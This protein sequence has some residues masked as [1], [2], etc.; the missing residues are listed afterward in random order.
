MLIAAIG[1]S[2]WEVG[3]AF[4]GGGRMFGR[5]GTTTRMRG[6]NDGG[7]QKRRVLVTVCTLVLMFSAISLYHG[8]FFSN[9]SNKLAEDTFDPSAAGWAA[10]LAAGI[11]GESAKGREVNAARADG[12][13]K[14]VK[15]DVDVRADDEFEAKEEVAAEKDDFAEKLE[16]NDDESRTSESDET[17]S[18]LAAPKA[19][20]VSSL[21]CIILCLK[22]FFEMKDGNR[23]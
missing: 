1:P 18:D 10:N 14:A 11:R 2:F 22:S 8:S 15:D 12:D 3:G 16:T 17:A 4:G 20:P 7:A 5:G 13:V 19:F 21:R 9:R 6:R 23:I